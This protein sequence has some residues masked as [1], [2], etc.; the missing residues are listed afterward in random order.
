MIDERFMEHE[1]KIKFKTMANYNVQVIKGKLKYS[2]TIFDEA[3][4]ELS[5]D[6][7]REKIALFSR[8]TNDRMKYQH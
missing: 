5:R 6:D 2:N 3:L 1:E 7:W 4:W 8:Q